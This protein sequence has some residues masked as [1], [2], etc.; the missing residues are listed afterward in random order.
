MSIISVGVTHADSPLAIR[1]QLSIATHQMPE[2]LALARGRAPEILLLSTC[3]RTEAI[4]HAD[5]REDGTAL[6]GL[7]ADWGRLDHETVSRVARVRRG[8]DAVSHALR[9]ASGL[10]SLVLGEDQIQSQFRHALDAARCADTLGPVLDRLGAAALACG[11]R[12]RTF[13]G[14]GRHSVSLES[15]AVRTVEDALGHLSTRTTVV[16]GAGESGTLVAR[17]LRAA[18]ASRIAI[19]SRSRDRAEALAA[20]VNGT[21][22][23]LAEL[24]DALESA[25]AI[26]VCTSAP[27]P[28]LTRDYIAHRAAVRGEAP[29]LCVDLGMPRAIAPD[30][31]SLAGV[32]VVTLDD[33]TAAADAHRRARLEHVPAAEGIVES[34]VSR[35]LAWLR[36]R[37]AAAELAE[38]DARAEQVA[39]DEVARALDRLPQADDFTKHII[40][41]LG[42]RL[43]RKLTHEPKQMLKRRNDPGSAAHG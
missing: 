14:V 10:D 20:A 3:N 35:Y 17:R 11:K 25:D 43:A 26:F 8:R 36:T 12:V 19:V 41:E 38:L 30:V 24:S 42:H 13:T 15:I 31:V 23:G 34:E 5:D 2:A 9:V 27:H 32:R 16:L 6:I 4:A 40:A 28:V 21:A 39:L 22:A 18:G 33:L 1:E 37:G 7:L 29:L